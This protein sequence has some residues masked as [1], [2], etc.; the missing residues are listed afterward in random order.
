MLGVIT[1]ERGARESMIK[2]VTYAIVNRCVNMKG[3]VGKESVKPQVSCI[4]T[5]LN[6]GKR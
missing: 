2:Y 5:S 1:C 4:L 6:F 3:K